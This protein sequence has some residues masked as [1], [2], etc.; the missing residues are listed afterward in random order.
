MVFECLQI[1]RST[2]EY[3]VIHGGSKRSWNVFPEQFQF[4]NVKLVTFQSSLNIPK[5]FAMLK[6]ITQKQNF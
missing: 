6:Q 1:T 3:K 5:M 2:R 4:L